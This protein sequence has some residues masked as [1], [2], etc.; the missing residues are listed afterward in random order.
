[1]L[2]FA[3]KFT[4]GSI[5]IKLSSLTSN[6]NGLNNLLS[7]SDNVYNGTE[8]ASSVIASP[9]SLSSIRLLK[10]NKSL[11]QRQQLQCGDC[12]RRS[13]SCLDTKG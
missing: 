1:M 4:S 8:M 12:L 6:S 2:V 10:G 7:R 3:N 13:N 11:L 5:S 9:K